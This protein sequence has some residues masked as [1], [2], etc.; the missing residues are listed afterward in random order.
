MNQLTANN[1]IQPATVPTHIAVI[2][3]G[4]RRWARQRGLPVIAGHR[5][6]ADEILEPLIE[7]ASDLGI[8]YITFWAWSTENWDRMP[9]EVA[10]IMRLF[11]HII[12]ERWDRLHKKGVRIKIIGDIS[13]FDADIRKS[14]ADVVEKTRNNTKITAVFALNNGG[15]DENIR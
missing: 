9:K 8:K 6:A 5:R 12:R 4:N 10:G 2:M 11:K 13:K 3:D 14:L 1:N 7:H 15:R